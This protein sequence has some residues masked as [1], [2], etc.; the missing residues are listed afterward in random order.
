MVWQIHTS[1]CLWVIPGSFFS[2]NYGLQSITNILVI[3][4]HQFLVFWNNV[5][6]V[7][8]FDIQ[9]QAIVSTIPFDYKIISA[10]VKS[11]NEI[12]A[13]DYIGNILWFDANI[14]YANI[15]FRDFDAI[16]IILV[17]EKVIGVTCLNGTFKLYSLDTY[18]CI[19]TFCH[20]LDRKFFIP[21][22]IAISKQSL[23]SYCI[24]GTIKIWNIETGRCVNTIGTRNDNL[25][26]SRDGTIFKINSNN[27]ITTHSQLSIIK[28]YN[29]ISGQCIKTFSSHTDSVYSIELF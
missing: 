5:S 12:Y 25:L 2:D 9:T 19:K 1:Q 13:C 18:N 6:T 28:I 20:S 11:G 3:N 26:N 29:I 10:F 17:N 27:I 14:G 16:S 8:L 23:A 15:L 4:D 21:Q 22:L 7:R 24:D